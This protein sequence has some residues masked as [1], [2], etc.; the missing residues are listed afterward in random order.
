MKKEKIFIPSLSI[1]RFIGA[2]NVAQLCQLRRALKANEAGTYSAHLVFGKPQA[3]FFTKMFAEG[4]EQIT[5]GLAQSF[6][7]AH[8]EFAQ[9][10]ID[11]VVKKFNAEP[12]FKTI[13]KKLPKL[14]A[15]IEGRDSITRTLF[16]NNASA[17]ISLNSVT[18]IGDDVVQEG[19]V[20]VLTNNAGKKI[21]LNATGEAGVAMNADLTLSKI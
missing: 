2:D 20:K 17:A 13:T 4:N 8:S 14:L 9:N 1:G 16:N 10:I 5:T 12:I 18:K 19:I 3:D 6:P 7:R 21:K 15:S 11:V